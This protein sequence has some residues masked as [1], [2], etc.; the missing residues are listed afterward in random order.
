MGLNNFC[1]HHDSRSNWGLENDQL[2]IRKRL[3]SKNPDKCSKRGESSLLLASN[4]QNNISHSIESQ[5]AQDVQQM[6]KEYKIL[7]ENISDMDLTIVEAME[8][9]FMGKDCYLKEYEP[10]LNKW[11]MDLENRRRNLQNAIIGASN[12]IQSTPPTSI[13]LI[14]PHPIPPTIGKGNTPD[15]VNRPTQGLTIQNLHQQD[16]TILQQSSNIHFRQLK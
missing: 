4:L 16:Q 9:G 1:P 2:G 8:E 15:Y 13:Q 3:V 5:H 14:L 6:H 12:N 11:N 7:E 10:L